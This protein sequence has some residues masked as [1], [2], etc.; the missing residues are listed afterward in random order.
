MKTARSGLGRRSCGGLRRPGLWPNGWSHPLLAIRYVYEGSPF[1]EQSPQGPPS[2][3][4]GRMHLRDGGPAV[5]GLYF[6]ATFLLSYLIGGVPTAYLAGKLRG[7]DVRQHGSGNVGATNALR[8]LGWHWGLPVM[9]LDILKGFAVTRWLPVL[10]PTTPTDA[11]FLALT[12]GVAVV[13]GH[14]FTPYLGFRGGKGVATGAGVLLALAPVAAVG[15]VFVFFVVTFG[16]RIV[17][18]GS[19]AAAAALP[20]SMWLIGRYT[21]VHVHPAVQWFGVAI[22]LFV[23]WTHRSNIHRLLAGTEN[24]FGRR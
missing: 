13:L 3:P 21:S 16:A 10:L 5:T 11:V 22:T 2:L 14:V 15:S 1:I 7:M 18:L 8:V 6:T 19:L 17:S 4:S 9:A 20:L 12:A 24:R 23:F